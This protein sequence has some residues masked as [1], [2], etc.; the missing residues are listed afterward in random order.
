ML[1]LFL[2]VFLFLISC[3]K[4]E[5]EY[6]EKCAD[7]KTKIYWIGRMIEFEKEKNNLIFRKIS[8]KDKYEKKAIENTIKSKEYYIDLYKNAHKKKLD[9]KI[10]EFPSYEDNFAKCSKEFKDNPIYFKQIYN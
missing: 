8:A 4:S 6:V 3:S 9:Q 5:K 7:T 10:Y 2:I 1:K